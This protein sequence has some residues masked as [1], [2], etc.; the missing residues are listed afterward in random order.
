MGTISMQGIAANPACSRYQPGHYVR[1]DDD[2]VKKLDGLAA[3]RKILATNASNLKGVVYVVSWGMVEKSQGVYD[4]SRIDAA[5]AQV[6]A[7]NKY[8]VLKWKDRVFN[9]EGCS[10]PFLPA[11]V[12]RAAPPKAEVDK[13]GFAKA[14]WCA[15]KIWEKE[16]MDHEIRVLKAIA[17][18]YKNEPNFIGFIPSEESTISAEGNNPTALYAQLARRN[19]ALHAAAPNL[20][21]SQNLNWPAGGNNS[22]LA[23]IVKGLLDMNGGGGIGMPD[24]VPSKA[25]SWSWYQLSRDNKDKL[26]I[27]PEFQGTYFYDQNQ[28]VAASLATWEA[29]Y[30]FAVNDLGAHAVVWASQV[31]IGGKWEGIKFFTDV[32]IPLM[33]K[34]PKVTAKGCPWGEVGPTPTVAATWTFCANEWGTC[35]FGGTAKVRYG[36]NGSYSS[37]MLTNS[38]PCTNAIFGDP[39]PGIVKRCEYSPL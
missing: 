34:Y 32:A 6:K 30:K 25:T 29:V 19:A 8:F 21:I 31:P 1:V 37:K 20:L 28:T 10:S 11:Y 27:F 4:F 14:T 18:R 12:A 5:L 33:A 3:T 2:N 22:S 36:A 38:T 17:A 35:R 39:L 16:T 24:T 7:Q 23:G 15:A 9:G 26:L 13:G